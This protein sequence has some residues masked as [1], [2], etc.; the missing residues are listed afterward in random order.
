MGHSGVQKTYQQMAK[1]VYWEGM[2]KGIARM[3]AECDVYQHHKY[4][5][6]ASGGLS[7]PLELPKKNVWVDVT[8][9]FKIGLPRSEGYHVIL[10]ELLANA[11][12]FFQLISVGVAKQLSKIMMS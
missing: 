7:Q 3:M 10:K 12:L 8:I 6:M 9:N 4:L 5:T 2:C 11:G 1:E